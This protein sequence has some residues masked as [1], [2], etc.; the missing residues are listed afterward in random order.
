MLPLYT[1]ACI[2]SR[3]SPGLTTPGPATGL[4]P[5]V[6]D[7]RLTGRSA[8]SHITNTIEVCQSFSY[9]CQQMP[10]IDA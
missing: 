7:F 10:I 1:L 6:Y 8:N 9:V 5:F 2:Q 4:L 3:L